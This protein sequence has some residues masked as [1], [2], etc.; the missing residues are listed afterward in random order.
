MKS[1]LNLDIEYFENCLDLNLCPKFLKFKPPNLQVYRN[2]DDL[3]RNI[4]NKKLKF[5]KKDEKKASLEFTSLKT[6]VLKKI[7]L[8]EK[9]FICKSK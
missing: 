9:L 7:S 4:L 3:Y 2:F 5:T 6:L 8:I 1:F